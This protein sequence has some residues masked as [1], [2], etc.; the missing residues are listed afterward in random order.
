[1]RKHGLYERHGWPDSAQPRNEYSL[2]EKLKLFNIDTS[3]Y[4]LGSSDMPFPRQSPVALSDQVPIVIKYKPSLPVIEN[5]NL[6]LKVLRKY[7][8]AEINH[9]L[10]PINLNKRKELYTKAFKELA[11]YMAKPV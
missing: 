4:Y 11:K 5:R 10:I 7:I 2:D 9:G 1:M 6:M 8:P 3:E